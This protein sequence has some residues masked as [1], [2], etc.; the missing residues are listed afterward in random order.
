MKE[1]HKY[2]IADVV[3]II[4]FYCVFICLAVSIIIG[5]VHFAEGNLHISRL[6]Y[7]FVLTA[8]MCVPY[9]IKKAFKI[10]FS[11]VV[12]SVYYG[13]MYLSGFLGVVL[14]FYRTY[15]WWDMFIHFLMGAILAV[16]SIYIL[17][18]T[19]YKKNTSKH[20]LFIT[21][22]FMLLFAMGISAMWEIVEFVGDLIFDLG[23]QRYIT[24]EGVTLIG[25][26]A[27]F[28]TMIDLTMDFLGAVVGIIFTFVMIK[29]NKR[30]LKTFN[31]K[32]LRSAEQEV[33]DIEE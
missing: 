19:I 33:E 15:V 30:F 12:S 3:N 7:R 22:L 6:I 18:L 16:L 20:N 25:K 24:Y 13:Y 28:D 29:I 9:I 10:T 8:L 11:R 1:K 31:I 32:K 17:N 21:F 14:E 26:E 2:H 4:L 27:L 23:F 5:I